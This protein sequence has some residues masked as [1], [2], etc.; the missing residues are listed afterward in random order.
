ME[1][2][3]EVIVIP[4]II[5]NLSDILGAGTA[6][7]DNLKNLTTGKLDILAKRYQDGIREL[8]VGNAPR[9]TDKTLVNYMYLGLISLMF[10]KARVV[11]CMRDPRDTCLSIFFQNFDE[12][13]YY[14]NRLENLGAYY[15]LYQKIMRH[16]ESL[17]IMPIFNIQY[18]DMVQNQ[19]AR[20]RELIEFLGLE[21]N[22]Q[23]LKF[24]ETKRSVATASYDQVR[25]K[26]YTKSMQR[27]KNYEQH[28]DPLVS[29]LATT[30]DWKP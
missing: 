1:G 17:C 12:S 15:S 2:V 4:N 16:W 26:M 11:H 10:P 18:E 19:E 13:H 20:S 22:D 28:I 23:V 5:R 29:A 3:G 14:A 7:P 30:G 27:W 9:V 21:W 24:Y 8:A 6:Y 25:Q